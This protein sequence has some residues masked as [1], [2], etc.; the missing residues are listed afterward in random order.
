MTTQVL[1]KEPPV[2]ELRQVSRTYGTT[3][4]VVALQPCQLSIESGDHV[5][6]MGPSGSGKSTLLNILGLL[7]VV[8]DGQYLL[9]G[10][11]VSRLSD[12]ERAAVRNNTLGFVFQTFHLLGY[13]TTQENVE[14]PMLYSA[15]APRQRRQRAAETLHR[16]GLD[17]RMDAFPTTLSGG[18]R[19][20]VAVARA[21]VTEPSLLLCDEPTGNLDSSTS[22]AILDL[23]DRLNAEGITVVVVTHE[24]QVADRARRRLHIHDGVLTEEANVA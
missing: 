22:T 23:L 5:A 19:Q 8:S 6:I 16:V 3:P 20:R 21:L 12:A 10:Q 1:N 7:D 4:P 18:E 9:R 2:V 15:T 17:H 13:R 14:I 24:P 11:E